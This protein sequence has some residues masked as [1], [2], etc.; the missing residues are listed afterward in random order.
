[1]KKGGGNHAATLEG[2]LPISRG[3]AP[4]RVAETRE[5]DAQHAKRCRLGHG[6]GRA[7]DQVIV[8]VVRAPAVVEHDVGDDGNA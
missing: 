6:K 5:R 8:I 4:A 7:Q 2:V 3:A 1:M